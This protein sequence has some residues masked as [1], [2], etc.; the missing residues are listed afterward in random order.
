MTERYYWII[1]TTQAKGYSASRYRD[2]VGKVTHRAVVR[3]LDEAARLYVEGRCS[4]RENELFVTP[5]PV[6][7]SMLNQSVT[8]LTAAGK[9]RDV[10]MGQPPTAQKL[11]S[12]NLLLE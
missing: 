8:I 5:T 7:R 6:E 1:V 10:P 4:D 9:A 11:K 12:L 2:G 3:A